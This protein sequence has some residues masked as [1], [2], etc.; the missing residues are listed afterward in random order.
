MTGRSLRKYLALRARRGD[1]VLPFFPHVFREGDDVPKE[2]ERATIVRVGTTKDRELLIEYQ[3]LDKSC[4]R[5]LVLGF[6]DRGIWIE[7]DK[8]IKFSTVAGGAK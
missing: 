8:T 2:L 4:I 6:G 3:P 7:Q 1:D 5:R